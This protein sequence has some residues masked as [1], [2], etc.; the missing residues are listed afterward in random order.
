VG[1]RPVAV[2]SAAG[3]RGAVWRRGA[4]WLRQRLGQ[5]RARRSCRKLQP[6]PHPRSSSAAPSASRSDAAPRPPP[7][8]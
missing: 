7:G 3:Q 5:H 2:K 8:A 6:A 1:G 4:W